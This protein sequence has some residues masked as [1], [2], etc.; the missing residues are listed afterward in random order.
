MRKMAQGASFDAIF[1][2]DAL[3]SLD[4][5]LPATIITIEDS[6]PASWELKIGCVCVCDTYYEEPSKYSGHN[7]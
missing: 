5:S 7:A 3:L 2:P 6:P 4:V 1:I